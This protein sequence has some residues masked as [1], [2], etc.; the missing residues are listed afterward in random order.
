MYINLS[1]AINISTLDD[2]IICLQIGLFAC[3][4]RHIVYPFDFSTQQV[5]LTP[6]VLQPKTPFQLSGFEK[7]TGGSFFMWEHLKAVEVIL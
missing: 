4:F 7:R 2:A 3:Y 5:D 6:G 1:Y